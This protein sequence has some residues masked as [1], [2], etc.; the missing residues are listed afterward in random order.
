MEKSELPKGW[1]ET[2]FNKAIKKIPLTGKKL[3]QKDYQKIGKLP[4][5]DQGQEFISGYTN[6]LQLKLDCKLPVIVFGDH[7][8]VIKYVNQPFVAG[9][10]GVT[11][12]EPKKILIP[13]LLYYFVQ[14]IPLPHKGYARHYQFLDKSIIRIPPQNEQK[15][16]VSKIEEFFSIIEKINA[17][18]EHN[19]QKIQN[20]KKMILATITNNSEH[21]WK[22][23]KLNEVCSKITDGTHNPPKLKDKGIPFI[24]ISNITKGK[25]NLKTRK[26]I[27]QKDFNLL[28]KRSPIDKDDILYST[29]GSYGI[30]VIVDTA[31]KFQFQRHISLLKPNKKYLISRYLVYVM[32]SSHVKIQADESARGIA[33]KTVN[34]GELRNFSIPLPPLKE[35]QEIVDKISLYFSLIDEFSKMNNYLLIRINPISNSILK[36][37]FEGKLVP[38]DPNDE[39]ASVLLEKIKNAN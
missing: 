14:A 27:S 9:A 29:V 16:I 8:K 36:N 25:L 38:Q 31:E 6:K 18:L 12:L 13:K 32:N 17:F 30:A 15:R 22:Q 39:P 1:D 5:I 23:V 4:V 26:F 28:S 10:D 33:Q 21:H 7:T 35:Q 2:K 34:L 24:F 37:A 3:K 19:N 20:L 11:V